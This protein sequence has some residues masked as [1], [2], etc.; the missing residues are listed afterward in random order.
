MIDAGKARSLAIMAPERSATFPDVPTLKEAMS[1]DYSTGAWRGFA[2]PKGMP[3]DIV[4]ALTAGM[5]KV[6][7]S[8]EFREFMS[9]RGFGVRWA[10]DRLT[11]SVKVINL[12]NDDVQQHVFGDILK[13]QVVGELRVQF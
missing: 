12:T 3:A 7:E 8:S 10:D 1:I 5:K 2:G 13:R 4:T 9:N 6:N 11:T